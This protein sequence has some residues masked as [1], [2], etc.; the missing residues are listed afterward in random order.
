LFIDF[1]KAFDSIRHEKLL[2]MLE[3]ILKNHQNLKNIIKLLLLNYKA[4]LSKEESII[5]TQGCAQGSKISP[6]LFILYIEKILRTIKRN[7]YDKLELV[8]A[9]ADDIVVICKNQRNLRIVI[10]IFEK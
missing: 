9:Y 10:E 1:K 8:S 4:S 6:K 3:E 2:E 7:L 5:I